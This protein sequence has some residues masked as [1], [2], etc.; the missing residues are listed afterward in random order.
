[1]RVAWIW[2]PSPRCR[3]YNDEAELRATMEFVREI[4]WMTQEERP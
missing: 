2:H 4:G 1:V 3:K